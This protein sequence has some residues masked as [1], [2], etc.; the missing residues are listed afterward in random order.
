M[1]GRVRECARRRPC[2]GP[3]RRAGSIIGPVG[4]KSSLVQ[5]AD[6][7]IETLLDRCRRGDQAAWSAL[8]HAH[9]GLVYAVGRRVGLTEDE[10]DDVAQDV[11]TA[12]ASNLGGIRH[13]R[14]IPAWLSTTTRREAIRLRRRKGGHRALEHEPAGSAEGAL[15]AIERHEQ[16]RRAVEWLGGRCRELIRELYFREGRSYGQIAASLGIPIGSI[17]PTRRRCLAQL[18]VL[19]DEKLGEGV[20]GGGGAPSSGE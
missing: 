9:G 3:H 2:R 15:E 7:Q 4:L 10:C 17:G 8:V 16:V 13:A 20:S 18:A 12:L 6:D 11:F 14:A 5:P 1:A 19:L